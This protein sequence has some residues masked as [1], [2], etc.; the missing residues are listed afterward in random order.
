MK[1]LIVKY[2]HF[3]HHFELKLIGVLCLSSLRQFT[4]PMRCAVEERENRE[5][6]TKAVVFDLCELEWLDS[7]GVSTLLNINRFIAPIWV[8]GVKG[9][10][11][12]LFDRL[13]LEHVFHLY[14]TRADFIDDVA[15]LRSVQ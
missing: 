12:I 15:F 1:D 10:V 8:Y 14:K 3:W 5:K 6:V 13:G 9:E 7:S 11:A 4:G 2:E